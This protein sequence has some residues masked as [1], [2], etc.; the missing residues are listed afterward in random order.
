MKKSLNSS[1]P[2]PGM[3]SNRTG[4]GMRSHVVITGGA[5]FIGSHLTERLLAE[6]LEVVV[7]DDCSTGS[8]RNLTNVLSHPGFTRIEGSVSSCLE[9]E[10]HVRGAS[11]VIHL[12]AAVG[13]DLV[14]QSPIRTIETNLDET[15]VVLKAA[16]RHG[17][18]VILASTS[19]VYGKSAKPAFAESDDLLIGP[20]YLARWSYA[21]SKLMDEFLAM[22]YA[23][24]RG[25]PVTIARFFNTVGPRQTGRY[26]MVVP[27]FVEAAIR[28]EPVRVFGSGAQSRCFCHVFDTVEALI[29]LRRSPRAHGEIVNIGSDT[30]ITIRQL[31]ETV[32]RLLDSRSE[33]AQVPYDQAYMPGFEDM[34]RRRPVLDKLQNLT[35]FRP[36]TSLE[37]IIIGTAEH[38]RGRL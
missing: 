9:L 24:E 2:D 38:I 26:G 20:P 31:A 15:E 13:V 37:Q 23:R 28:N 18:H 16:S 3:T 6:G 11:T 7:I 33:I 8:W 35:G 12:A 34:Q 27:R 5:G 17:V 19:E 4:N 29:R 21:C 25:L 10:R 36:S 22:A 30:E 32:I 14:V 1:D